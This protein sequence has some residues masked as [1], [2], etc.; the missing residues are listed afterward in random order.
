[1]WV[2]QYDLSLHLASSLRRKLW[3]ARKDSSRSVLSEIRCYASHLP[4]VTNAHA[5][6]VVYCASEGKAI[7][8]KLTRT[9]SLTKEQ[10][11]LLKRY[12]IRTAAG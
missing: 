11:A 3:H 2:S 1:M 5:S 8:L 9:G 10:E 4:A 7:L 6:R 12:G